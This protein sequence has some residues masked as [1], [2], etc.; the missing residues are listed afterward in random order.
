M[1]LS[2]SIVLASTA[3]AMRITARR[4]TK[5][6]RLADT[7]IH[8]EPMHEPKAVAVLP[9]D[10]NGADIARPPALWGKAGRGF[11]EKLIAPYVDQTRRQQLIEITDNKDVLEVSEAEQEA[12]STFVLASCGTFLAIGGSIFM[13]LYTCLV[14]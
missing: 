7:L 2:T 5:S 8:S 1:V 13:P 12:K 4:K 11:M 10:Q 14:C 9:N 6:L 3:A